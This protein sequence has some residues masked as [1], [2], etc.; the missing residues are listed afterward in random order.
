MLPIDA[1]QRVGDAQIILQVPTISSA[2]KLIA[3]AIGTAPVKL[4][5]RNAK[6]KKADPA[7]P[8]FCLAHDEAASLFSNQFSAPCS[9][10]YR[11]SERIMSAAFSAIMITGEFVLP[12]TMVGMIDASTTRRPLRPR[13]HNRSSTTAMASFPILQVPTG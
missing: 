5:M 1:R 11:M 12:D 10:L 7:H 3:E 2:V 6:G 13:T 8:A 4:V 9:G